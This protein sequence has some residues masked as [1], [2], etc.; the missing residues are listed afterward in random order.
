M[1][2]VTGHQTFLNR[3]SGSEVPGGGRSSP[4]PDADTL[5]RPISLI[6]KER[7]EGFSAPRGLSGRGVSPLSRAALVKL[8][9]H[10]L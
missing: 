4:A 10:D 8:L 3:P 1:T 5:G 7:I 2:Y 6:S 9:R